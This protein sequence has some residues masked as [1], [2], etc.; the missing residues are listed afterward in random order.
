M[1]EEL[2]AFPLWDR[3]IEKDDCPF[4]DRLLSA[5]TDEYRQKYE[6]YGRRNISL[7]TTAPVGSISMLTQTTSGIE[8][9][10]MVSYK[11]RRKVNAE[12]KG[13]RVDF[14]DG[15]GDKWQE[16]IVYHPKFKLWMDVTGK[17]KFEDSPYYK[18]T[19]N[20]VDWM[21]SVEIQ[22]SAQK[23]VSHAI[24]KTCNLPN[25]ATK[26][27]VSKIY[28]KAWESGCKGF[29]VYRDGCRTGV[30]VSVDKP[31]EKTVGIQKTV[32]PK[33][34]NDLP[35]D[36]HHINQGGKRYY[37]VVGFL[38][39]EVY[40]VFTGPNSDPEGDPVVPKSIKDGVLYKKSRGTYILK[41][42]EKEFSCHLTNGH[43]DDN[44]D[45][46]TRMISAS[47]RHGTDVSFIVH[48]LEKTKGDLLSFSKV[49]A[50]TL[51]K[52]I[53]DNTKVTGEKCPN[54]GGEDLVR[55]EGC[56]LC[57]SCGMSKC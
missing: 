11:R 46:L 29:T 55:V 32:A 9:A 31:V 22:A 21:K 41:N 51:K 54:C 26:E 6:K 3:N 27:L 13:G 1:A 48:Q 39:G 56:V 18:A 45:A 35:C 23:W 4:V 49:L 50:R 24:S 52:Y 57:K 42:T 16:Y 19:S 43:S 36:V 5:C 14:V 38:G 47:L 40:E 2:G 53:K 10:F 8:P 20:D 7:T 33:R 34:P 28:M 17:D 15:M 12:D 44:A 30:L 37:V 25:S